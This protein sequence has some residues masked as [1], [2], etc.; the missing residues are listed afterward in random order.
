MKFSY[1]DI[2]GDSCK[3]WLNL[4][5]GDFP[6]ALVDNIYIANEIRKIIPKKTNKPV[7]PTADAENECEIKNCNR[8]ANI[9]A[10]WTDGTPVRVCEQCRDHYIDTGEIAWFKYADNQLQTRNRS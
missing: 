4:F 5:F 9:I 6:V 10:E 3:G 8:S 2:V 7:E 1:V